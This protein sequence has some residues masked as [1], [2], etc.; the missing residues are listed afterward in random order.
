[1][2]LTIPVLIL[3]VVIITAL[4]LLAVLGVIPGDQL[5]R[6]L[7]DLAMGAAGGGVVHALRGSGE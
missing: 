6:W 7:E 1:M 2:K 3:L 5:E 4:T